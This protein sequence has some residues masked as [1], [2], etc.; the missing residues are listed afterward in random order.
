MFIFNGNFIWPAIFCTTT[1]LVFRIDVNIFLTC[2]TRN[3]V[4]FERKT[5]EFVTGLMLVLS[6]PGK[7]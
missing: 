2:E 7:L 3:A 6:L 5:P 4:C 1:L